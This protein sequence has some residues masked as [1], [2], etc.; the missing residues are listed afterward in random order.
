MQEKYYEAS[1]LQSVR[2]I[3]G[4]RRPG[5]ARLDVYTRARS[6]SPLAESL[7]AMR[8]TRTL[9]FYNNYTQSVHTVPVRTPKADRTG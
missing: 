8:L 7:G 6:R 5:T 4:R 3:L 2:I 1:R 9:P